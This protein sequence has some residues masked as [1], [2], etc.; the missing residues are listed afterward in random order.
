MKALSLT[1]SSCHEPERDGFVARID[2]NWRL[3]APERWSKMS[4]ANL[5]L[6]FGTFEVTSHAATPALCVCASPL[7]RSAAGNT[8]RLTDSAV[9]AKDIHLMGKRQLLDAGLPP[10]LTCHSFR[11]TTATDL[12]EQGVPI[13]YVQELLG[14]ADLRT[15][16]LYDRCDRKVTRSIVER[17]SI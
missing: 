4:E 9:D 15:T 7:F 11:A 13:E 14:P 6:H 1:T 2:R 5:S 16:R 8:R 3:L 10:R 17:I 12:L